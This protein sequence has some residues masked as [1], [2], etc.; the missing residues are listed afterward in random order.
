M[1]GY[2][3]EA[4]L[5]AFKKMDLNHDN[6]LSVKEFVSGLSGLPL[7]L[8]EAEIEEYVSRYAHDGEIDFQGFVR[9]IQEQY[10]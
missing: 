9:L 4:L 6:R 2:N 1:I 3:T 8:T 10:S 7:I 5:L